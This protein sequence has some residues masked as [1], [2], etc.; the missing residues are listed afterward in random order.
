MS[1][2]ED[3]YEGFTEEEKILV[4]NAERQGAMV[5]T[6]AVRQAAR[7]AAKKKEKSR[8][9]AKRARKARKKNR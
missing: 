4:Q 5:M 7:A 9:A 1:E 8:A 3:P 2:P 6:Q